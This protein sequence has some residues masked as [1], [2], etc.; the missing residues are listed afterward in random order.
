MRI[1]FLSLFDNTFVPCDRNPSIALP[2]RAALA[3]W[4]TPGAGLGVRRRHLSV[5]NYYSL[6]IEN[7]RTWA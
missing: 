4:A 1:G 7:R 2:Y 5:K 3:D 6:P